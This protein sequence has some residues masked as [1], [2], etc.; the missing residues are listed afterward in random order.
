M[1][2]SDR[3]DHATGWDHPLGRAAEQFARRV[4]RDTR[5]FAERIEEHSR[6]FAGDIARGWR[7]AEREARWSE[8]HD[9][10]GP[11]VKRIF[12]DIRAVLTDV[13]EGVDEF[14]GQLFPE[15]PEPASTAWVRVIHNRA[16]T[17]AACNRPIAVGDEG[18]VRR[19]DAGMEYRC[20]A[21]DP[22]AAT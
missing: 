20:D 9:T 18:Y 14:I 7:R 17:C 11:E 2:C 16:A 8:L 3:H 22:G 6:D 1:N 13:I 15:A 12:E 19:G 21:C 4:A 10:A 5:K